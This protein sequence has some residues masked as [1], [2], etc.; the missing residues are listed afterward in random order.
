MD[1][2]TDKLL[3]AGAIAAAG[4]C[5]PQTV[6]LYDKLG[7]LRPAARDTAGRRLYASAQIETLRQIVACRVANRGFARKTG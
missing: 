6:R 3:T 2:V 5:K 1:R 7:L 4:G